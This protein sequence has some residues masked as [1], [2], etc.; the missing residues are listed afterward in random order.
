[1]AGE[2]RAGGDA[3]LRRLLRLHRTEIAVA[4]DSAFPLLHAL[5]DH[6][7][8][9]EDKF[10]E[11]LRLKE[12]EGCPQAFH[13]LLSWLLTQDAGAILDFWR[14]LFKDYNLER[15]VRLQSI[16]DTFPKEAR[17]PDCRFSPANTGSQTKAKPA[18]KPESNAEPQRLP[19]GNGIQ[20]MSTSVQRAMAVSSGDVPGARGAVEGILIQQVFESGGS[21]KC[22]QVGGEFYTPNKFEDPAGGKNKTRSSSLKSLV[23]AKGTQAPAPGGGD[24]RAGPRDRAPAPP[25][26]PSEPHLHQAFLGLRSGE[27]VRA[28]PR[29]LRPGTDAAVTYKHLLAPPSAAPLPGPDP[30]ALCPPLCVGPEGQQ[31][32][33][34]SAGHEP[35]LHRDDLESL[36]SEDEAGLDEG[37]KSQWGWHGGF[38]TVGTVAVVEGRARELT[39]VDPDVTDTLPIMVH[40]LQGPPQLLSTDGHAWILHSKMEEQANKTQTTDLRGSP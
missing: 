39:R 34:D 27:E 5:A 22:I 13:A 24:S 40:I 4:V 6:D 29:E 19:L 1:M 25:A 9:P 17:G 3:A 7:V 8:V 31:V 10:Q 20:T 36:L 37:C 26:L 35:V 38:D 16:L 18:K 28:L 12:K 21:K 14:V 2:A 32:G 15:Y 11:T 23:R 33:D 30:S